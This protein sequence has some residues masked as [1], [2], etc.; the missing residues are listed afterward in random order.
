MCAYRAIAPDLPRVLV[1]GGALILEVGAGQAPPIVAMLRMAG[2][3][4]LEIN[5]DLSG[6]PRCVSGILGQNQKDKGSCL[7]EWVF[8]KVS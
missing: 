3:Q 5:G 2:F 8:A 4:H 7:A 1:P 6:N